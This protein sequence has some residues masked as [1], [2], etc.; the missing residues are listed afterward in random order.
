M[1]DSPPS[2]PASSH[3]PP[4]VDFHTLTMVFI[5]TSGPERAWL[6][7]TR[8]LKNRTVLDRSVCV[9]PLLVWLQHARGALS[10][11]NHLDLPESATKVH[12]WLFKWI[13]IRRTQEELEAFTTLQCHCSPA[14]RNHRDHVQG[15]R[16]VHDSGFKPSSRPWWMLMSFCFDLPNAYCRERTSD[17]SHANEERINLVRH[18][19]R[20][21][22]SIRSLLPHGAN[23]S[24]EGVIQWFQ[25]ELPVD[26]RKYLYNA[27]DVFLA[28][29]QPVILPCL[30]TSRAFLEHGVFQPVSRAFGHLECLNGDLEEEFDAHLDVLTGIEVLSRFMFYLL[31]RR[32]SDTESSILHHANPSQLLETYA[33]MISMS[34]HF[35]RLI[36]SMAPSIRREAFAECAKAIKFEAT[37][38][39]KSLMECCRLESAV[40]NPACFVR[41]LLHVQFMDL[42]DPRSYDG[43][44]WQ[45][46]IFALRSL[47]EAQEC[48]SPACMAYH[49]LKLCTGCGLV[50]YCS[51]YC[52]KRGWKHKHAPHRSICAVLTRL[53][54]RWDI[55]LTGIME[56]CTRTVFPPQ[57]DLEPDATALF[58][59]LRTWT[60][61]KMNNMGTL[62]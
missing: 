59:H 5:Q 51:R 37:L 33:T 16:L 7:V 39:A 13:T 34:E 12:D 58:Q 30:I 19:T 11:E 42:G 21:P 35:D 50:R 54:A 47:E 24:F 25:V 18:R 22:Y 44:L 14:Q 10:F 2:P 48:T 29:C 46:L 9:Y 52:Q 15:E 20:W 40:L 61:V 56:L 62:E 3:H 8:A 49:G 43:R 26:Q 32:T 45:R 1:S 53:C 31:F 17:E 27:L 23:E 41:D 6:N 38:S 57:A 55:P 4:G 60:L 28:F 36:K